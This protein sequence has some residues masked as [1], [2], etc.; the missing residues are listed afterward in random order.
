VSCQELA[1]QSLSTQIGVASP[2]T[3]PQKPQLWL[4]LS[5]PGPAHRRPRA[6]PE[7]VETLIDA[8]VANH[9]ARGEPANDAAP[10]EAAG[11]GLRKVV[12]PVRLD[13]NRLC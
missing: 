7:P 6:S 9:D 13:P 4:S 5:Q 2:Q 12:E 11:E 8:A 1:W 10:D 3:L